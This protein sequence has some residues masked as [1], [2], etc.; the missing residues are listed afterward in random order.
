MAKNA[1]AI[2]AATADAHA[3]RAN[4]IAKTATMAK[5]QH[6]VLAKQPVLR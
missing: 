6:R 2:A 4:A 3:D 1:T 5:N